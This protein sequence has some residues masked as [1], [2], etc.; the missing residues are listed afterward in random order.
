MNWVT[1]VNKTITF[2]CL[3]SKCAY[4]QMDGVRHTNTKEK[5]YKILMSIGEGDVFWVV[6]S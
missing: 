5:A 6:G 2:V 3:F 1:A 4:V